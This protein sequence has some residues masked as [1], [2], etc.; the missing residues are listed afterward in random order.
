MWQK[1]PSQYPKQTKDFGSSN[2]AARFKNY[3]FNSCIGW[4]LSAQILQRVFS[5]IS[6]YL[7]VKVLV[8][9]A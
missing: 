4:K 5:A 8:L 1:M 9:I 2:V 6:G 7:L 3:V